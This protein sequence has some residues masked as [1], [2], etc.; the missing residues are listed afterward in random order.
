MSFQLSPSILNQTLTVNQVT[1]VQVEFAVTRPSVYVHSS[2]A[3]FRGARFSA[4]RKTS[5]TRLTQALLC[6]GSGTVAFLFFS[7]L[8]LF[9]WYQILVDH[10]PVQNLIYLPCSSPFVF[11]SSN[12]SVSLLHRFALSGPIRRVLHVLLPIPILLTG[13]ERQKH[14]VEVFPR[15][16]K[17]GR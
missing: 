8:F 9:A 16:K 15:G 2:Y 11:K 17:A 4:G 14:P 13:T 5:Q 6:I 3:L 10:S 1:Y 12:S 7:F